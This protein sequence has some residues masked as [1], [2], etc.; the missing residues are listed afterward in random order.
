[1]HAV[2]GLLLALEHRTATGEGA[3]VEASM[4]DAALSITAEQII[5]YTATGSILTRQGNRGP[6]A[7]P[8][9]LYRAKDVDEFGR[10]DSWVALAVE[11]DID[12]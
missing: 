9:G 2:C 3:L 4:I 6:D 12:E 5:E 10:L 7:A 1:M 11:N 8:Q